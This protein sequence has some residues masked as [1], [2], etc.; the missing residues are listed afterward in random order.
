MLG[1][2]GVR[3]VDGA[4]GADDEEAAPL[5]S[6][7]RDEAEEVG[8]DS[9][10]GTVKKIP[11]V[12]SGK[13]R[14]LLL[15]LCAVVVGLGVVLLVRCVSHCCRSKELYKVTYVFLYFLGNTLAAVSFFRVDSACHIE[16]PEPPLFCCTAAAV[17][18]A[19]AAVKVRVL[20]EAAFCHVPAGA[21][22]NL[23]TL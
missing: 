7:A 18:A 19:A 10:D 23:C 4:S 22:A 21:L 2:T 5:T 3:G 15:P 12:K 6:V 14:G 17:A 8:T 16:A 9:C 20:L 11:T 1:K 13:R